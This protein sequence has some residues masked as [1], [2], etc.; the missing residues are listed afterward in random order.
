M[1]LFEDVDNGKDG[2][3]DND[4][5]GN[6]P[7]GGGHGN[8]PTRYREKGEDRRHMTINLNLTMLM[9]CTTM[10]ST[11]IMPRTTTKTLVKSR[12][13]RCLCDY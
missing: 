5:G 3:D 4:G 13:G 2:G 1:L 7:I 8:K 12:L 10:M 6:G 9:P 11:M